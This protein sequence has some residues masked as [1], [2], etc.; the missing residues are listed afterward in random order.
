MLD[1]HHKLQEKYA[2]LKN[3]PQAE[4]QAQHEGITIDG[5]ATLVNEWEEVALN[6]KGERWKYLQDFIQV[7][8]GKKVQPPKPRKK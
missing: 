8:R 5:E 4:T 7:L 3:Q 6:A 1:E 2:A